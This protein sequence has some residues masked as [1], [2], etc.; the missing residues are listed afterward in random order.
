MQDAGA[1]PSHPVLALA[2]R[3]LNSFSSVNLA[4]FPNMG[5]T[6]SSQKQQQQKEM[7]LKTG[8]LVGMVCGWSL[9]DFG[10]QQRLYCCHS[11]SPKLPS[12][13]SSL[14]PSPPPPFLPPFLF[15]PY[16]QSAWP[17]PNLTSLPQ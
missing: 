9:W 8:P 1:G 17:S 16:L 14:L 15:P 2:Q 11:S 12:L 3:L 13:P 5:Q 10:C 4:C 7:L 6:T